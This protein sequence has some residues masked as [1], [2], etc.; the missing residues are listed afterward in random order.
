MNEH[1]S[2]IIPQLHKFFK[3]SQCPYANH[4]LCPC[5]PRCIWPILGH[6]VS[7]LRSPP[8]LTPYAPPLSHPTCPH[9]HTLCYGLLQCYLAYFRNPEGLK[10]LETKGFWTAASAHALH[11]LSIIVPVFK[12]LTSSENYVKIPARKLHPK[13]KMFPKSSQQ[14]P[15]ISGGRNLPRR[16]PEQRKSF[17]VSRV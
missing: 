15:G 5:T 2:G 7:H 10:G 3:V 16:F 6:A 13:G 17:P 14:F 11:M 8:N 9:C 4:S 12:V 1:R